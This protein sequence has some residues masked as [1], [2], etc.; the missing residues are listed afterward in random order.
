MGI[1]KQL[2]SPGN[3]CVHNYSNIALLFPSAFS[4]REM[5]GSHLESQPAEYAQQ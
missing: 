4:E 5:Q 1:G 3:T 2:V